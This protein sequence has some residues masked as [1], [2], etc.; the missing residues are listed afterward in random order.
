MNFP[1]VAVV[2]MGF[3]N[4]ERQTER[5]KNFSCQSKSRRLI[6]TKLLV[7]VTEPSETQGQSVGMWEKAG[8]KFSSTCTNSRKEL[9]RNCSPIGQN[10]TKHLLCPIRRRHPLEFLEIA[11]WESVPTGSFTRLTRTWKRSSRP[12]PGPDWLP[13]G[14]RGWSRNGLLKTS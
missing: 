13:L 12:F 7:W 8:R 6:P 3:H 11:R 10:N 5:Q 9:R 1:N 14:L 2:H 4:R